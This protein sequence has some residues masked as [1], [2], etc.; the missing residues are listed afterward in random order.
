[1]TMDSYYTHNLF[2]FLRALARNNNREWFAAHKDEYDRL[3]NLWLDDLQRLINALVA[4]D[5]RYA[6]MTPK[7]AA[8]RIY[9]D[10]RFS[11]DKTPY[12]P[13]FSAQ[14]STRGKQ[15]HSAGFYLHMSV[16]GDAGLYGGIWAPEP[17]D[18]KK[19]RTAIIDN[20]D[21]FESIISDPA[22]LAVYPEWTGSMLKTV[23]KGY[24]RNH[25]QAHLLRLKDIGR[26]HHCDE[27]FFLDPAWPERA[28]EM[29]LLLQPLNDFLDYSLH[30]E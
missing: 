22:M 10:T 17:A 7:S 13:Y 25:P 30:E 11:L 20:I 2:K 19:L 21:E 8:F 27:S 23:P 16:D 26:W 6:I 28:A 1:M 29:F 24:D 4:A 3:R 18:L 12:K 9:R 15:V 5:S 14:F